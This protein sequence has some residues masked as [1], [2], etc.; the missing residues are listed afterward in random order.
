[1]GRPRS[2]KGYREELA[3]AGF[4]I[5]HSAAHGRD[6]QYAGFLLQRERHAER[7]LK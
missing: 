2:L 5:L 1:M 4:E 7:H 3:A 6:R